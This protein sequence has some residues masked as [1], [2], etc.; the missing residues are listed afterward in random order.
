MGKFLSDL[1]VTLKCESCRNG[2]SEWIV[3]EPLIYHSNITN[4]RYTAPKGFITD[5]ASVP[6]IP[7]AYAL[8]GDTIHAPAAIH[9]WL[10]STGIE[11]RPVADTVLREAALAISVPKWKVTLIYYAVRLFGSKYYMRQKNEA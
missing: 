5:F 3:D 4:K 2:R 8:F 9:D 11:E 7:L 6:R 10:Y 1:Q